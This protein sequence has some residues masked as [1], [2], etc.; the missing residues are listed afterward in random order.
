MTNQ[1]APEI[2]LVLAELESQLKARDTPAT[3]EEAGAK[4]FEW[5]R[6]FPPGALEAAIKKRR[7]DEEE[8]AKRINPKGIPV[9]FPGY[10]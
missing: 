10:D 6:T 7:A 9:I 5:P 8:I 3:P 1:E 4:P 2:G